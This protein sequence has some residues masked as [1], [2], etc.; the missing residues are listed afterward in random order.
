MAADAL[1]RGGAEALR[2][3][4]ETHG[5]TALAWAIRLGVPEDDPAQVARRGLQRSL[6]RLDRFSGDTPMEVWVFQN[7]RVELR[8]ARWRAAA[9]RWLPRGAAAAPTVIG[10]QALVLR[11]RRRVQAALA[12]LPIDQR[13]AV[14]LV[15]LEGRTAGQAAEMLGCRPGEVLARVAAARPALDALLADLGVAGGDREGGRVLELRRH[16]GEAP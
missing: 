10:R 6:R 3:F 14:V 8:R 7:L 12:R 9:R 16:D 2:E 5:P 13:E 4:T 1:R 11:R 15:E